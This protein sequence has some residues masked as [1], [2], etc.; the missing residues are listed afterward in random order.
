MRRLGQKGQRRYV[1]GIAQDVLRKCRDWASEIGEI[2][3][4]E[5]ISGFINLNEETTELPQEIEIVEEIAEPAAGALVDREHRLERVARGEQHV[6][7]LR[8]RLELVAAQLVEQRLH[9]VRELGQLGLLEAPGARQLL[10]VAVQGDDLPRGAGRPRQRAITP[11]QAAVVFQ[12]DE[13]LGGGW[14]D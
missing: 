2:K 1:S 12:G 13:V 5:L 6:D 7:H 3:I 10:A 4:T 14:I 8:G 11:G 9:L